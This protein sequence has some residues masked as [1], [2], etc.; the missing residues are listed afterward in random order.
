MAKQ[1]KISQL[2]KTQLKRL[3]QDIVLNSLNINDYENRYNID[4]K[5]VCYFFDS[6]IEYIFEMAKNDNKTFYWD[7]DI[8]DAY[9]NIQNLYEYK[10]LISC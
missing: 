1:L 4:P 2:G 6:Y 9:D 5:A 3:R 10:C 7:S 8:F